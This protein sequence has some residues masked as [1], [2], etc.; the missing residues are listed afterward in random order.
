LE[1]KKVK[2]GT[3]TGG[4][5]IPFYENTIPPPIDPEFSKNEEPALFPRM[6]EYQGTVKKK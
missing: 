6:P 5:L 1:T 4:I 3:T 2:A